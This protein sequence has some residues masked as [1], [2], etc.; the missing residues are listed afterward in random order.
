MKGVDLTCVAYLIVE[1]SHAE[2]ITPLVIIILSIV[3][4]GTQAL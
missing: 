1:G 2:E 3:K 4:N